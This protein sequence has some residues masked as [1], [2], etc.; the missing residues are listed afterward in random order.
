MAVCCT[1]HCPDKAQIA[2]PG[3]AGRCRSHLAK[4]ADVWADDVITFQLHTEI[5]MG[6]VIA[7]WHTNRFYRILAHRPCDASLPTRSNDSA[8]PT[9]RGFEPLRAEPNGFRVHLLNRSD[10][11]SVTTFLAGEIN[12]F[13][14]KI[15][16]CLGRR[17]HAAKLWA[18]TTHRNLN[19]L[20]PKPYGFFVEEREIFQMV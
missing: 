9:A 14:I 3:S 7:C 2:A 19:Y 13:L 4:G 6:C 11:V 17:R 15:C 8:A 18:T 16:K 1:W 10:T 12:D 5:P 20:P